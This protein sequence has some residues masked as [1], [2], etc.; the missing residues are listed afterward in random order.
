MAIA[1]FHH[2]VRVTELTE[3]TNSIRVVSTA[4]IGL[5]AT[6][7]DADAAA[8]PYNKPVLF[9]SIAK[10]Q[11]KAGTKGT[12]ATALA[13]IAEQSRPVLVIALA[14][15]AVGRLADRL[16]VIVDERRQRVVDAQDHGPAVAA[17]A[18]VGAA[19][20]LELLAVDGRAAV[21]AV[22]RL[23]GELDAVDERGNSHRRAILSRHDSRGL[24][25]RVP[26]VLDG[27]GRPPDAEELDLLVAPNPDPAIDSQVVGHR[28][29][30][31]V[32]Q[33]EE[34][35]ADRGV[36]SHG[37]RIEPCG[38]KLGDYLVGQRRVPGDPQP[39][40]VG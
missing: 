24:Q 21:P 26:L 1:D 17:V 7:S 5:V 3:G 22:A 34:A 11:A 28:V 30:E 18:A 10:A 27:L 25:R 4:I 40:P 8:F 32:Q 31:C 9:T 29:A 36:G 33:H 37:R 38:R 13:C 16:P 19:E 15:L 35:L 20:R 23:D 14:R 12:L 6:A 39:M 2:G